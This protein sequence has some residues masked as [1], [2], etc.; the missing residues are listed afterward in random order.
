MSSLNKVMLIGRL[1]KDPEVQRFDSGA[2][3]ASFSLATS[4]SY[5]NRDGVRV[6]STEWHNIV[7]WRKS[8]E[9]AERYLRKGKLVYIEGRIKTRSWDDQNGQKRYITEIEASNF[10]MLGSRSDDNQGG[11]NSYNN[12][13]NKSNNS[14]NSP[15]TP[16]KRQAAPVVNQ[17]PPVVETTENT[18]EEFDDLPF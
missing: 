7:V 13:Y 14:Q 5:T 3:K 16:I 9:I 15:V 6:E 18:V 4:E 1:G 17:Q 10:T 11:G 8:A 12:N 2:M